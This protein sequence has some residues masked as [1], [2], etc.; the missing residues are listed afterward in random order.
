MVPEHYRDDNSC[1]CDDESHTEMAE[2]GYKWN[3]E[4]WEGE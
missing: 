4:Q 3:G 1:R 2:W